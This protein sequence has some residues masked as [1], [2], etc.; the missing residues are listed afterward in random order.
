MKKIALVLL[1]SGL[2]ANTAFAESA[3]NVGINYSFDDVFGS[4][5][6]FDIAKATN[7]KPISLQLFFKNYSQRLGPTN[8]WRT[9]AIGAAGIYDLTS[10]T[11]L[12]KQIHPYV[13][14]GLMSVSYAWASAGPQPNYTGVDGGLYVVGGIRYNLD[15]QIVADFNF[16][17]FGGLTLGANFEF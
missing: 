12:D 11:K 6:E 10:A 5:L 7:N 16:N 14:M 1:S 15:P 13:G 9:T 2:L 8:T 3:N 17:N 4:H